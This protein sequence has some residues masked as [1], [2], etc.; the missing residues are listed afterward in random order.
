MRRRFKPKSLYRRRSYPGRPYFKVILIGMGLTLLAVFCVAAVLLKTGDTDVLGKEDQVKAAPKE[1]HKKLKKMAENT[2]QPKVRRKPVYKKPKYKKNVYL[3]ID[4]GPCAN[5]GRL[6]DVL[7]QCKVKATFFV[8]A[9]FLNENE[10]FKQIQEIDRRGHNVAVH[11]YS[12]R[13]R[14]IYSSVDAYIADY[15]K[16]DD[17][18]F[19]ATG[20]RSKIFR[21][22]GGSNAGYNKKIRN[23]LLLRTADM[24][25]THYD[26]NAF[27]GDAD[28]M[29][30]KRMT[31]RA[32]RESSYRDN[33]ILLTHD[34]PD[35]DSL[36]EGLP[37]IVKA[38]RDKGYHWSLLDE[39]VK[40]IQFSQ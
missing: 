22:P 8:T 26:W 27:S 35:K 18:I 11:T 14:E 24:G 28:G 7:D 12:H 37:A 3:T 33:S 1:V 38:M 34:A 39:T 4:D 29:K 19:R 5:T 6:L 21:F 10:L 25:L 2:E 16:M 15:K 13:Y 36:I 31:D 40:P 23:K 30:G 17:L 20:K 32:I 9:Q